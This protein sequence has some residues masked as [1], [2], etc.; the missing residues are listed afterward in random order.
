MFDVLKASIL[1]RMDQKILNLKEESQNR[2]KRDVSSNS[3]G[4]FSVF[5]NGNSK[6]SG[7]KR[8]SVDV[9]KYRMDTSKSPVSAYGDKK[10]NMRMVTD[11]SKSPVR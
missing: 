4:R 3:N 5:S 6:I 11:T 8:G 2:E 10:K 7:Y 1:S 9:A